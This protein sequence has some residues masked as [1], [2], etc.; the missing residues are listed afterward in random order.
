MCCIVVVTC[1]PEVA[2]WSFGG[3]EHDAEG[4]QVLFPNV[5]GFHRLHSLIGALR[6]L[7]MHERRRA[8]FNAIPTMRH[9]ASVPLLYEYASCDFLPVRLCCCS[10]QL[11]SAFV[12]W[13]LWSITFE[14]CCIKSSSTFIISFFPFNVTS[15][16]L[17][18][19]R[20]LC[21]VIFVFLK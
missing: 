17:L 19:R 1:V 15:T 3:G 12:I 8:P 21:V 7:V 6:P 10:A 16:T 14:V 5:S 11:S 2:V 13:T 20:A 4:P 18:P 9:P